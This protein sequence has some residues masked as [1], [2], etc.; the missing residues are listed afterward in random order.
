MSRQEV[1]ATG[2]SVKLSLQGATGKRRDANP[3][4]R[5]QPSRPENSP[6]SSLPPGGPWAGRPQTS[7]EPPPSKAFASRF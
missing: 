1:G 6:H 4:I 5:G 2:V 7:Q 3:L